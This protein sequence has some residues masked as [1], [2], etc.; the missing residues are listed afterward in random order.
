MCKAYLQ[1]K[2]LN[3]NG[4]YNSY[5]T[6]SVEC[7]DNQLWFHK[8]GLM[9]TATGYGRKLVTPYMVKWN[10]KTYRVYSSCFSNCSTEYIISKGRKIIVQIERD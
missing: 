5:L 8:R 3:T 10:N 1:F 7:I 6:K 9:Q 4:S 2:S